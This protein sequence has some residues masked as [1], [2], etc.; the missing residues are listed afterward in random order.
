M[1]RSW[2]LSKYSV[3]LMLSISAMFLPGV[4]L[5]I[6][7][8][9]G[10]KNP[11]LESLQ[12]LYYSFNKNAIY[13]GLLIQCPLLLLHKQKRLT[14]ASRS[15]SSNV[16][17]KEGKV[18]RGVTEGRCS[19]KALSEIGKC[20]Q[21]TFHIGKAKSLVTGMSCTFVCFIAGTCSGKLPSTPQ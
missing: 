8:H 1:P 19:D 5:F 3:N 4:W 21:R 10:G 15:L 2:P 6:I 20:F 14:C 12:T 18:R 17:K 7:P 13:Y 11:L 16:D 9:I